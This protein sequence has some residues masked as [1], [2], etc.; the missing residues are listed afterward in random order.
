MIVEGK[1]MVVRVADALWE[2]GCR[3]VECQ[4]GDVVA[5]GEYGIQVVNDSSPGAGPVAAIRDALGRHR[6]SSV[7]VAACD[8]VDLD[9]TTVRSVID[10]GSGSDDADV[11]VAVTRGERH[12]IAWWRAGLDDRVGVLFAE[13]VTSYRGVLARLAGIE[14]EVEPAAVRN[15]N[16]PT[17]IDARG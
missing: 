17:D 14:V 3:H 11:A 9:E 4:G 16:T 5:I 7:V 13:G 12:L 1:P 2:A 10:A 6:A 15:L 8:L